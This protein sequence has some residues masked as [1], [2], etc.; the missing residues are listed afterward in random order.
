MIAAIGIGTLVFGAWVLVNPAVAPLDTSGNAPCAQSANGGVCPSGARSNDPARMLPRDEVER[1]KR[2]AASSSE[3]SPAAM[4]SK[5]QGGGKKTEASAHSEWLKETQRRDPGMMPASPTE[6]GGYGMP[7]APTAIPEN[8]G[9]GLM[10]DGSN[11]PMVSGMPMIPT[12]RRVG[13]PRDANSPSYQDEAYAQRQR[14][15]LN[16]YP[17]P[18]SQPTSA[19]AFASSRPFSSGVSPYMGLFRNDTAGG[20]ID[21]YSTLVRPAIDQRS[22]NQQFNSDIYGLE[23]NSKIQNAMLRQMQNSSSRSPRGVST[24]QY[25]RAYGGYYPGYFGQ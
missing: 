2:Y 13:A 21:N 10:P 11:G 9:P 20:T 18:V 25:D 6:F 23:R 22:M 17:A 12:S 19:K 14:S 5:Q 3:H 16:S 4:E 8:A 24:P 15:T 1:K 7:T